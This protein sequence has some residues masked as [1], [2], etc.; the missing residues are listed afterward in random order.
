MNQPNFNLLDEPWIPVENPQGQLKEV[1]LRELFS[2]AG[3]L[4]RIVDASPPVT[5]ALYRLV[6][7]ITSRALLVGDVEAWQDA[8]DDADVQTEVLAYLEKHRG[9]FDL[10]SAEAPFSQVKGMPESCRLFPWTKLALELPPNS[11]KLLFDHTSTQSPPACNPAT[12]A[13]N[14]LASIAFTVGA[15]KSCTGHTANAPLT[16][17]IV[18]IPEGPCL[19]DTLLAN[20]FTLTAD[21]LPI[22]ERPPLTASELIA[23]NGAA[24]QGHAERLTWP[25]RA[26]EL[27]PEDEAGNIRWIRFGM[28][29]RSPSIEGD[30]DPWV[31]Y[32]TN[33]KGD[34]FPLKLNPSRMVWRD[35][36]AMLAGAADGTRESVEMVTRLASLS[37]AERTPPGS[38]TILITAITADKAS[39]K[40]WKQERWRIPASV[41]RDAT[42]LAT[43]HAAILQAEEYGESVRKHVWVMV[44]NLLGGPGT[45]DSSQV[46]DVANRLPVTD[47]YWAELGSSFQELLELLGEDPPAA[48]EFWAGAIERNLHAAKKVAFTLVGRDSMAL[49]AWAKTSAAFDRLI[50]KI[51]REIRAPHTKAEEVGHDREVP[52]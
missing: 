38:W 9:R 28:G 21:D 47:T 32:Q 3:E 42:S 23:Q 48:K 31:T 1:S 8:W 37:D 27:I 30:R 18:V 50:Y 10:F 14:L 41:L 24:W 17:A 5:A 29:W 19:L 46:S 6:F 11:S 33:R 12:A 2:Q 15:G 22:W 26:V 51:R 39:I 16:A 7:T 36:H 20:M 34:R 45:A 40:A 43:L 13:R 25:A 49:R 35:F 44:Q 52:Q 4:K